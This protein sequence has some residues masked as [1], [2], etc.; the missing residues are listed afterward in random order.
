MSKN[1]ATAS[2]AK[3]SVAKTAGAPDKSPVNPPAPVNTPA[4]GTK[5][6]PLTREE[7]S[8]LDRESGA[9]LICSHEGKRG[10]WWL[11]KDGAKFQPDGEGIKGRTEGSTND[12]ASTS[13]KFNAARLNL[14]AAQFSALLPVKA[15][16]GTPGTALFAENRK[17]REAKAEVGLTLLQAI[18]AKVQVEL[19]ESPEK[20][21]E[22]PRTADEKKALFMECGGDF[23]LFAQREAAQPVVVEV[24]PATKAGRVT[25]AELAN[26][27]ASHIPAGVQ[28]DTRRF[29]NEAVTEA[30]AVLSA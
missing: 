9:R 30:L 18:M 26:Q 20:R 17:A 8:K 3:T 5:G 16:D 7:Y 13:R 12:G 14:P 29:L 27:S 15:E 11:A 23:D 21:I 1:T 22:R 6:N 19:P 25:L 28:S 2:P 10:A 4:K 24:V